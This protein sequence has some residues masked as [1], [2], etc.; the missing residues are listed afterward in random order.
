MSLKII[1]MNGSYRHLGLVLW[2]LAGVCGVSPVAGGPGRPG[3]P[4]PWSDSAEK[5]IQWSVCWGIYIYMYVEF[6]DLKNCRFIMIYRHQSNLIVISIQII[7]IHELNTLEIICNRNGIM[8][9]VPQSPIETSFQSMALSR[10]ILS[11]ESETREVLRVSHVSMWQR[12]DED[13]TQGSD[14]KP[15]MHCAFQC[16]CV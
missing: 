11:G 12:M 9:I 3:G 5:V 16:Q 2:G 13:A 14:E 10:G 7:W 15:M 6:I 4:W 1:D 8:V